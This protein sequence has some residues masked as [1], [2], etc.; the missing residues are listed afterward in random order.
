MGGS[1]EVIEPNKAPDNLPAEEYL[2][3]EPSV[4]AKLQIVCVVVSSA[5]TVKGVCAHE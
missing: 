5:G 4:N 1:L 3:T 2:F